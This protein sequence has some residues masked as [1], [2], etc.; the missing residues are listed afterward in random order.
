MSRPARFMLEF[1]RSTTMATVITERI[2]KSPNVCGGKA[3]VAG[4]RVRVMDIVI[5]HEDFGMS[6]DEIV[7]V[8]PGLNLSDIHSALAYYFDN[9]DEIRND[10]RRNDEVAD[11]LRM[12]FPSKLK[13][14]LLNGADS[15]LLT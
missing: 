5:R 9:V 8:Y 13:T 6:P 15:F 7:A 14:K 11:Q 12:S 10:I 3:C 1:T 2:T 4:L